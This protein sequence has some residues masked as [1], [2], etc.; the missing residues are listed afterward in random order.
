M[1]GNPFTNL[2]SFSDSFDR[3]VIMDKTPL[4]TGCLA[5]SA[6]AS[7]VVAAPERIDV[8]QDNSIILV[9][10][11]EKLNHGSKPRIR[12]KGNQHIVAIG[13]DPQPLRGRK[14]VR[15]TL[16]CR[17]GDEMIEGLTI[18]TIQ[19]PW[20][21]A[22]STALTSGISDAKNWGWEG[23]RFP[24]VSGGNSGSLVCQAP[25][26]VIDGWYH[27]EVAPDLLHAIATGMAHGLAL[28]EWSADY[29]RNPT[30][31][32]REDKENAPYLLVEFDDGEPGPEPLPAADLK[33][34]DTGAREGMRLSLTGPEEGFAY[35]VRVNGLELPRWNIP[36]VGTGER[37][38]IALRDIEL[39]PGP[40]KVEVRTVDR[41]GR[42][43]AP[44]EVTGIV[45]APR[46]LPF[47]VIA[48]KNTGSQ[49]PKGVVVRPILDRVTES[50]TGIG[51][52]D[53]D[54][55]RDNAIWNGATIQLSAARGEVVG[56]QVGIRGSGKQTVQCRLDNFRTDLFRGVNVK[57]GD[58]QLPD[59]LVPVEAD[60][61]LSPDQE[62]AVWVDVYV[63][64]D[65]ASGEV[66][67][68]FEI[69]DGRSIPIQLKVRSFALP[70][71]ASFFCEMNTYGVPDKVA[72]Y[73]RLQQV[74]YDHR[75]HINLMHY[76]H[77]S[78]QPGARKCNM[79]MRMASGR[80]MNEKAY[81]D[82]DPGA[83]TTYW[84]DFVAVFGPHLSGS[85]YKDGH[86]GAIPAP[87][88]YLTFHESWPLN[89]RGFWNGD[90]DAY[91]GFRDRPEYAATYEA[92]VQDFVRLAGAEG[93]HETGFQ[94]YFNNKP[95]KD[96]PTK[97]PWIL[98]EPSSYWDYRALNYYRDLTDRGRGS[99]PSIPLKYRIDI[100]RPQYTRGELKGRHDL[101]VVS[102]NSF[103]E[104]RRLVSDRAERTGEEI[105]L[106]GSTSKPE[107]S[108]RETQAW[109]L[110]AYRDGAA[111]VVPWQTVN[112][113]GE[114]L[115]T[116]DQLGLFIFDHEAGDEVGA[117]IRHSVRLKAY[118]RAE[119]D[120]EYLELLR[121]TY[122]LTQAEL[123]D[124]MDHYL[125]L[126]AHVEKLSERDAGT[127]RYDH[128]D[129]QAF[130]SLREA[131]AVLIEEKLEKH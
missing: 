76:S 98:D 44:V 69:G 104:N 53:P 45:P 61:E 90:M 15:A 17:Q 42:E 122:D 13:I 4:L 131:A 16:V 74:A 124:F 18:S 49:P 34:S 55:A 112:K 6:A 97:N 117:V 120:I 62:T 70:R 114:A 68:A 123:Q 84:D 33:I 9:K 107:H 38:R 66:T 126:N 129:P 116:A 111:G 31:Y 102:H 10:S 118:R 125:P 24:G 88:F 26:E 47:P 35:Q 50:G 20:D 58:Q 86:R 60:L 110:Q 36:F 52:F 79:D 39:A 82:I 57:A 103:R 14:V 109:A 130:F 92:L 113:S 32:A 96:D 99:E 101:R 94:I 25:G 127:T 95:G 77:G 91:E 48:Q 105:W 93:W 1:K 106:Y 11:E 7:L 30:I 22:G 73:Y 8:T 85:H 89:V 119:Q 29:G 81:N 56:F 46:A 78:A 108:A 12:I 80:R 128:L 83:T 2:F 115:K 43:S 27:W 5:L 121:K 54:P 19:T 40:L 59:P 23:A 64:F 100:S 67:G 37:Q 3:Q 51:G 41:L 63:P 75:V 87:G 21:E 72:E 71:R 65:A 28:H